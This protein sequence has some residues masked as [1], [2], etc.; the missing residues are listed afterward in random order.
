MAADCS[1]VRARQ[2]KVV[3]AMCD[4]EDTVNEKIRPLI[5]A[6]SSARMLLD[7]AGHDADGKLAIS[8]ALNSSMLVGSHV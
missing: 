1:G 8:S 5:G 6:L 7:H 2:E 4:D 3:F